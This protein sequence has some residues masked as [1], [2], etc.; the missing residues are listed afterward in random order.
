MEEQEKIYEAEWEAEQAAEKEAAEQADQEAA[1]LAALAGEMDPDGNIAVIKIPM[2]NGEVPD[3]TM[4]KV[5]L[6]GNG[7]GGHENG[8]ATNGNATKPV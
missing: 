3:P 4:L 8:D 6:E 2:A 5:P 7:V 1:E